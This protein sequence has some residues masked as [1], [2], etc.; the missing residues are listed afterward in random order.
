MEGGRGG[1][2]GVVGGEVLAVGRRGGGV[3]IK[4]RG[5]RGLMGEREGG[6]GVVGMGGG[7]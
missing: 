3:G 2:T 6:V 1:W 4:K 5:E 7:W